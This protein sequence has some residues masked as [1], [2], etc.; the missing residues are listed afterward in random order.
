[1]PRA[2]A[3]SYACCSD[4]KAACQR[5]FAGISC[6]QVTAYCTADEDSPLLAQ[7]TAHSLRTATQC[8]AYTGV[9]Y[10][11]MR[12]EDMARA[13]AAG[14][15]LPA[16]AVEQLLAAPAA[17]AED[18]TVAALRAQAVLMQ[19]GA[20]HGMHPLACTLL[21]VAAGGMVAAAVAGAGVAVV[22][23]LRRD[24]EHDE[25]S[26]PLVG[27][28]G[29]YSR[30]PKLQRASSAL[31]PPTLLPVSSKRQHS[32]SFSHPPLHG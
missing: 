16:S 28:A 6:E 29:S 26:A 3:A 11:Y 19:A 23:W 24:S 14:G 4:L 1:M 13:A 21:L 15:A 30:A 7:W 9:P 20:G 5:P 10:A 32:R 22:S 12:L 8:A 31:L 18:V 2:A 17:A 27:R 25:L